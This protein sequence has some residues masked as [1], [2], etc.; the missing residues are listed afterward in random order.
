MW[1]TILAILIREL[2]EAVSKAVSDYFKWKRVAK[3]NKEEANEI[4]RIPDAKERA[5]RMRDFL[6]P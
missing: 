3:E 4:S 1:N 2:I 6:N 5:A